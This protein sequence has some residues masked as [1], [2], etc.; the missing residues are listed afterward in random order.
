MSAWKDNVKDL[1]RDL[2]NKK[3]IVFIVGTV[4]FYYGKLPVDMWLYLA[5][6]FMATGLIEQYL[7]NKGGR[8]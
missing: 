2:I 3:F 7:E 4:F 6:G 5:G 8:V 1:M